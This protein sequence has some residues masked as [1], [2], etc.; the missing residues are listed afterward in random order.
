MTYNCSAG[1]N[2][3]GTALLSAVRQKMPRLPMGLWIVAATLLF[4]AV[5]VPARA[6]TE[7]LNFSGTVVLPGPGGQHPAH[8]A[9]PSHGIR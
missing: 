6:D 5:A 4:L 1:Q 3:A 7:T 9:G 8:T 2:C